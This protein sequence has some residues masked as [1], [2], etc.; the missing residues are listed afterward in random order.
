LGDICPKIEPENETIN[1]KDNVGN[2][3]APPKYDY[4][5]IYASPPSIPDA[6]RHLITSSGHK[7]KSSGDTDHKP[8]DKVKT[9]A[10]AEADGK[11]QKPGEEITPG[12][13]PCCKIKFGN[14]KYDKDSPFKRIK[15]FGSGFFLLFTF[16][17]IVIFIHTINFIFCLYAVIRNGI[18]KSCTKTK[19]STSTYSKSSKLPHCN[20]SLRNLTSLANYDILAWDGIERGLMIAS[21]VILMLISCFWKILIDL[22]GKEIDA[23]INKGPEEYTVLMKNI[24][25]KHAQ[26]IYMFNE[27]SIIYDLDDYVKELINNLDMEHKKKENSSNYSHPQKITQKRN[28]IL[29]S[30]GYQPVSNSALNVHDN[31]GSSFIKEYGPSSKN[32]QDEPQKSHNEEKLEKIKYKVYSTNYVY[33]STELTKL[34][35]ELT[36]YKK[37]L[38]KQL[39]SEPQKDNYE[40]TEDITNVFLP[41]LNKVME[42]GIIKDSSENESMNKKVDIEHEKFSLKFQLDYI[43]ASFVSRKVTSSDQLINLMDSILDGNDQS[44]LGQVYITFETKEMAEIFRKNF[45]KKSK[46]FDF[47]EDSLLR[48]NIVGEIMMLAKYLEHLASKKV[49]EVV[50]A[51]KP[52]DIIWEN[53]GVDFKTRFKWTIISF[54]LTVLFLGISFSIAVGMVYAEVAANNWYI[55]ALATLVNFITGKLLEYLIELINSKE[56]H[57][58]YSSLYD[59]LMVKTTLVGPSDCRLRLSTYLF[60]L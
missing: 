14:D 12:D 23:Q 41:Q 24:D 13:C 31:E 60:F 19:N 28:S 48:G 2:I 30:I 32:Q 22:L 56:N 17:R 49:L 38:R 1:Q 43:K 10:G 8:G 50:K 47:E 36:E 54:S 6:R 45:K 15:K 39:E 5:D 57:K 35:Q 26:K 3:S 4:Y 9:K 58:L 59:S 34:D 42:L 33:K 37:T 11:D 16:N 20:F 29:P 25:R 51:P 21:M 27:N 55:S 52:T 7:N 46:F 18:G 44:S 40:N 53:V